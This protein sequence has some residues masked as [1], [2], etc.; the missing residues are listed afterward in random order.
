M[1]SANSRERDKCKLGGG[2][3]G[4]GSKPILPILVFLGMG[5]QRKSLVQNHMLAKAKKL[6]L[7]NP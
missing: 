7:T 4:G 3:G 5:I 1:H 6:I 2:G